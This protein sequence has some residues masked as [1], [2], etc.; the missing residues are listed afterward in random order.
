MK[1]GLPQIA[2]FDT[3][4]ALLSVFWGQEWSSFPL[5]GTKMAKQALTLKIK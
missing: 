2:V 1:S 3:R 4:A 5:F